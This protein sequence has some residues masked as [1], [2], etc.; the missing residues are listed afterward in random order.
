MK[1]NQNTKAAPQKKDVAK[2]ENKRLTYEAKNKIIAL[3]LAGALLLGALVISIFA[4]VDYVRR[5]PNFD[6]LTSD[7]DKYVYLSEEDYRGY[8]LKIDIAKPRKI[9]VDVVMLNLLASNVDHVVDD[10]DYIY[11]NFVFGAGDH[12]FIRYRGFLKDD[13]G[14]TVEIS[15]LSNFSGDSS[16]ELVLGSGQFPAI[17]VELGIVGKNLDDFPK[18]KKITTG[19]TEKDMVAYVSYERTPTDASDDS[20]KITVKSARVDLSDSSKLN[21]LGE[22]FAKYVIDAEIGTKKDIPGVKIGEKTYNYK[23]FVIDFAT[24]C[25]KESTNGGK[26]IQLIEGYFPYDYGTDGTSTAYLRNENAYFEIY[27]EKAQDY[28]V[29]L[30]EDNFIKTLVGKEESP[31]TE[32]ELNEKYPDEA[33]LIDKYRAYV[34]DFL[35]EE[36]E[37]DYRSAVEDAM[38]EHYLAKADFKK[39]PGIKVEP[40]YDEYVN[41][42]YYQFDQT[43][44]Q[45]KDSLTGEYKTYENI[46]DF[47]IAYLGLTYSNEKDWRKV[48]YTMSESLV[49]ERLILYYL[50]GKLDEINITPELL[51]ETKKNVKQEYLDEYIKQSL[52]YEKNQNPDYKKPEGEE[53]DKFVDEKKTELFNYYDDAYFTE[54]AYYEIALDVFITLPEVITLDERNAYPYPTIK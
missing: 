1:K 41:D 25:E 36:Y 15:G 10:G 11:S 42:V 14:N 38:W 48:L 26:P 29:P 20:S 53:Y 30:L 27:I 17:G 32:A 4:I 45:L 3:C 21:S 28:A 31:I 6:Y 16:L 35:D 34:K 23:N 52:E 12:A 54:T 40:I 50:I 44:G 33:T 7:L 9:D 18:F 39:Y 2:V 51:E 5:D 37:K 43:G 8:E 49:G 13:D 24:T 22:D 47:A 19:K 46:D